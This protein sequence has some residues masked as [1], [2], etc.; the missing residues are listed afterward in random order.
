MLASP[1]GEVWLCSLAWKGLHIWALDRHPLQSSG[2]GSATIRMPA[3]WHLDDRTVLSAAIISLSYWS[4]GHRRE[5][6][7]NYSWGKVMH[8]SGGNVNLDKLTA[9]DGGQDM[10]D[11][12]V[13]YSG[14]GFTTVC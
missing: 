4:Y 10:H 9:D 2:R 13:D 1:G 14:Q 8:G 7:G 6:N 5:E 11:S 12:D 3:T